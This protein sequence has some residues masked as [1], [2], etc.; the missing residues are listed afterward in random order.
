MKRERERVMD[1]CKKFSLFQYTNNVITN[2]L[3]KVIVRTLPKIPSCSY[4][5]CNLW[6]DAVIDGR[7][8]WQKEV[9]TDKCCLTARK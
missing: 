4:D 5:V 1:D 7:N 6:T 3:L 8:L 2:W 9:H